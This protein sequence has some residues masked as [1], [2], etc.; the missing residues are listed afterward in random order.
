M[1]QYSVSV[2][3]FNQGG[4]MTGGYSIVAESSREAKAEA[5]AAFN[6]QYEG[7]RGVHVTCIVP[8]TI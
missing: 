6:A 4:M 2:S 8:M 5:L 7:L 1:K 3:G